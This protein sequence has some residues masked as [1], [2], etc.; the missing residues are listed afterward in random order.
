MIS[1]C[2]HLCRR[3]TGLSLPCPVWALNS[4]SA[5][6]YVLQ[7][8]VARS[9]GDS[10]STLA[11]E[12]WHELLLAPGTEVPMRIIFLRLKREISKTDLITLV[13]FLSVNVH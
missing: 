1:S 4:I 9:K 5:F 3:L 7:M 8:S 12:A 11:A 2:N 6:V 10:V 13:R